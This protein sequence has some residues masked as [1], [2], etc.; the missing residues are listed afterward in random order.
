MAFADRGRCCHGVVRLL[1]CPDA[2]IAQQ[3]IGQDHP[4]AHDCDNGHLGR[5]SSRAPRQI[6]GLERGI[7]ANGHQGWHIDRLAQ[8]GPATL[9]KAL[10]LPVAR[11]ARHRR[12]SSQTGRLL[13]IHRS[14]LG[15]LDQQGKRGGG[16]DAGDADQDIVA[17]LQPGMAGQNAALFLINGRDL[18]LDLL[19]PT[20]TVRFSNSLKSLGKSEI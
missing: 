11:L 10:P 14:K 5:L 1:W 12:Q 18:G 7:E 13:G 3:R 16:P 4:L 6:L 9:D 17:R 19:D 8:A 15:H 2:A 20:S